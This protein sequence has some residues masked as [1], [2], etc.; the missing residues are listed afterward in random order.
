MS[1]AALMFPV[2][3]PAVLQWGA[4]QTAGVHLRERV[5][6]ATLQKVAVDV[7]KVHVYGMLMLVRDPE[8]G[9]VWWSCVRSPEP[10]S[11]DYIRKS[12]LDGRTFAMN[13]ERIAAFSVHGPDLHVRESQVHAA[14]FDEARRLLGPQ[15]EADLSHGW[16]A[17]SERRANPDTV[18]PLPDAVGEEMLRPLHPHETNPPVSI[19]SVVFERGLWN[20]VLRNERG[21]RATL[22]LTP[23]LKLAGHARMVKE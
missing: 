21:P 4:V 15:V 9:L 3:F 1:A 13:G 18:I 2:L 23:D 17:T 20:V 7:A 11:F 5:I 19:E 6:P 14:G 22:Q 16:P 8:S 12:E 10:M